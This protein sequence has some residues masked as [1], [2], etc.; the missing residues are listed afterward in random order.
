ME[1]SK[2]GWGVFAPGRSRG[3]SPNAVHLSLFSR[4]SRRMAAGRMPA[5]PVV[6]AFCP[7]PETPSHGQSGQ[8]WASRPVNSESP[9][10]PRPRIELSR[11]V[12]LFN[13]FCIFIVGLGEKD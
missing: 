4:A 5:P 10:A 12:F 3:V 7:R 8:Y 13:L 2:R 6:R 1:S 9:A 11:A